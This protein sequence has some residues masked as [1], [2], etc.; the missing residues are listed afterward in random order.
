MPLRLEELAKTVDSI[1]APG[2][3]A[4]AVP[5]FCEEA[6]HAHFAAVCVPPALVR[7][8]AERLRGCDV[9]VAAALSR[10][11]ADLA[12]RCVAAGAAEL[13]VPLDT[14]AMLAGEFRLARAGLAAVVGAARMA[15][16]NSGR[17]HA[18]VKVVLDGD[19]LD[20]PRKQLACKI[21]ED[22]DADFAVLASAIPADNAA[23]WDVELLRE[24]LPDRIGVKASGPV[25]SREEAE[26]LV[27][28]GAA[29]VGTPFA[30][31]V[32]DGLAALRR[33]S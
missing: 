26:D 24:R 22:V 30:G 32:V 7:A 17:G 33:A 31:A 15:S 2:T 12:R 5:R 23:V 20:A 21:V 4:A 29:R 8:T 11:S 14:G 1:L 9:K 3:G 27:A 25:A 16:V 6:A 28:A 18:L 19:R 13:D 10:P